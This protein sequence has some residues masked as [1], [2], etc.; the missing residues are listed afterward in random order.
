V[1]CPSHSLAPGKTWYPLYRRLGGPRVGLDRCGK[2][3]PDRDSIPGPSSQI[4][5][6]L[7]NNCWTLRRDIAQVKLGE[8]LHCCSFCYAYIL[9]NIISI[10]V[11]SKFNKKCYWVCLLLVYVTKSKNYFV[12]QCI[13]W[14]VKSI[15][16]YIM[17]STVRIQSF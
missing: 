1:S 11:S 3:R 10:Q 4:A 6:I 15:N 5:S 17:Q 9:S 8:S 2:S 16:L 13:W 14:E 12:I 7:G